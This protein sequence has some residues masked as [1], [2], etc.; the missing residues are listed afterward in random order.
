MNKFF[1]Y[2]QI[3]GQAFFLIIFIGR[4]LYLR[5]SKNINPITLGVGKRGLKRIVELAFFVGLIVCY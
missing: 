5:F 1:D 3:A 4:T 2:F